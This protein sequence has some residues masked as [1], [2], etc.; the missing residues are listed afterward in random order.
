MATV[1]R[2]SPAAQHG[3]ELARRVR[4]ERKKAC[5]TD[6]VVPTVLEPSDDWQAWIDHLAER[7][8]P[9]PFRQMKPR[10]RERVLLWGVKEGD[11]EDDSVDLISMLSR[12]TM[13][14]E[15]VR[16]ASKSWLAEM[17]GRP[18]SHAMALESLAWAYA[19]PR[20]ASLLSAATW[21]QLL[22]ALLCLVDEA[23]IVDTENVT[24][25]CVDNSLLAGELPLALSVLLPEL[26]PCRKLASS[27]RKW[28]SSDIVELL[29]GQGLP[30]SVDLPH[31]HSLLACYTRCSLLGREAEKRCFSSNAQSEYQWLVRQALR[32]TR[33]DGSIA[34]S[35]QGQQKMWRELIEAALSVSDDA[36]D[37]AIAREAVRK[38]T[39]PDGAD[40][41]GDDDSPQYESEWACSAQ[42]RNDWIHNEARLS[43]IYHDRQV[44]AELEVGGKVLLS[45][46]WQPQLSIDGRPLQPIADWEQVCYFVDDDGIYLELEQDWANGWRVQR[47]FYLAYEDSF[48]YVADAVLGKKKAKID[49][50]CAPPLGAEISFEGA[51]ETREGWL[52]DS[53]RCATVMPIALPEWRVESHEG[54]LVEED[55]QLSLRQT[56]KGSSLYAPLWFDLDR[57]RQQKPLTW[58]QLTVAEQ[59]EIQPKDVAVGFLVRS[60]KEQWLLYRS[61][62]ERGNRTLLGQNTTSEFLLAQ[63]DTEGEIEE[64]V[65]IE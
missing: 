35:P 28:L 62:S 53:K 47:Q 19:M 52:A 30:R 55:Q 8:S 51:K 29:D 14:K 10:R 40:D 58:R 48:F 22:E 49:Y 42:L 25:S 37:W 33:S 26:K 56:G 57:R 31:L 60:N 20:L 3:Q 21:W 7:D 18:P 2:K 12:P 63:F 17:E 4:R 45:G 23:E 41:D 38:I 24:G 64:L 1:Y 34:F 36:D 15:S 27:S 43:V 59:L 16:A 32:W 61:M 11:L 54:Q 44:R 65:E 5:R 9:H 46:D 6:G 39:I 50:C 13:E